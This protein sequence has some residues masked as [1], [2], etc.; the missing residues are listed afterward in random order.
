MAETLGAWARPSCWTGSPNFGKRVAGRIYALSW[1]MRLA[2]SPSHTLST[3]RD[4]W[5]A[6][7]DALFSLHITFACLQ[8]TGTGNDPTAQAKARGY[9]QAW[10]KAKNLPSAAVRL[11][12]GSGQKDSLTGGLAAGVAIL[13]FGAWAARGL[14]ARCWADGSTLSVQFALSGPQSV[15]V[16]SQYAPQLGSTDPHGSDLHESFR[17]ASSITKTELDKQVNTTQLWMGDYNFSTKPMYRSSGSYSQTC[18]DWASSMGWIDAWASCHPDAPGF[19]RLQGDAKSRI[20]YIWATPGSLPPP[21]PGEDPSALPP[22]I[23]TA[24]WVAKATDFSI[25]NLPSD[26]LPLIAELDEA[27]WIGSAIQ[28]SARDVLATPDS[29]FPPAR[30]FIRNEAERQAV[31]KLMAQTGRR[32]DKLEYEE[33]ADAVL[34]P[35]NADVVQQLATS[36]SQC[37]AAS[38]DDP[39]R[40]RQLILEAYAALDNVGAAASATL[41]PRRH[42]SGAESCRRKGEPCFGAEFASLVKLRRWTRRVS[43]HGQ[44]ALPRAAPSASSRPSSLVHALPRMPGD[45]GIPPKDVL[46]MWQY[47]RRLAAIDAS[48]IEQAQSSPARPRPSRTR[49]WSGPLEDSRG[50]PPKP[51]SPQDFFRTEMN[52]LLRFRFAE[53]RKAGL[54]RQKGKWRQRLE[55]YEAALATGGTGPVFRQILGPQKESIPADALWVPDGVDEEGNE[56]FK[57]LTGGEEVLAGVS[58]MGYNTTRESGNRAADGLTEEDFANGRFPAR[59]HSEPHLLDLLKS[60]FTRDTIPDAVVMPEWT[61]ERLRLILS[62]VKRNTAA[63][64]SGLSYLLLFHAPAVFQQAV[65]DL[66]QACQDLGDIPERARHSYIFPIAKSGPRGNTLDGARQICLVEVFLKLASLN[67]SIPVSAL[68][69]KERTLHVSQTG[70]HPG[71]DAAATAAAVVT[72]AANSRRNGTP[73]F[74]F[75]ADVAKAFQAVPI[76]GMY[77]AARFGGMSHRAACYWLQTERCSRTGKKATCQFVTDFGLSP[78]FENETGARMGAPPSPIKFNSWLDLL[79]RW[80]DKEGIKGISVARRREDGSLETLELHTLAFADDLLLL[81]ESIED[82]QR[83]VLLVDRFLSLF[84]VSL[85]PDKSAVVKVGSGRSAEWSDTENISLPRTSPEGIATKVAIHRAAP[86]EGTRYLGVW[87]QGDGRWGSMKA[88]VRKKVSSW[89]SDL[90]AAGRGVSASR[91]SLF[92][93]ATIGGYLRYVFSAAPLPESLATAIDK[94]IGRAVAGRTGAGVGENTFICPLDAAL[95]VGED[96]LGAFSAVALRRS[97]ILSKTLVRLI[98]AEQPDASPM[99]CVWSASLAKRAPRSHD[100]GTWLWDTQDAT[101][102]CPDHLCA[103]RE[104]LRDCD[105]Q[106]KDDRH[107]P[108][109]PHRRTW[110]I[111]VRTALLSPDASASRTQVAAGMASYGRRSSTRPLLYLGELMQDDGIS[112]HTARTFWPSGPVPRWFGALE[113]AILKDPSASNRQVM[114]RWRV[115][116]LHR[117]GDGAQPPPSSCAARLAPLRPDRRPSAVVLGT[118]LPPDAPPC[119]DRDAGYLPG[120]EPA[121]AGLPLDY[122]SCSDGTGGQCVSAFA[123]A[124]THH[125]EDPEAVG[126]GTLGYALGPPRSD[127]AELAG[128]LTQLRLAPRTG[129][130]RLVSDCLAMLLLLRWASSAPLPKILVHEHRGLLLEWRDLLRFQAAPPLLGWMRG[131]AARMDAPYLIQD[132][133]DRSAPF[134]VPA[135]PDTDHRAAEAEPVFTLWDRRS[136]MPVREGWSTIVQTR[137]TELLRAAIAKSAQPGPRSWHGLRSHF[138]LPDEWSKVPLSQRSTEQARCRSA[139]QADTT[140]GPGTR[141]RWDDEQ[142]L[143]R[144]GDLAELDRLCTACG[145]RFT[146]AWMPHIAWHC[147][148]TAVAWSRPDA[149]FAAEWAKRVPWDPADALALWSAGRAWWRHLENGGSWAGF[150][151]TSPALPGPTHISP[152]AFAATDGEP[153]VVPLEDV[154]RLSREHRKAFREAT[155]AATEGRD[156]RSASPM[157]GHIALLR[158]SD[159]S[160]VIPMKLL[161]LWQSWAVRHDIPPHPSGPIAEP[162]PAFTADVL[163]LLSSEHSRGEEISEVTRHVSKR[164]FY[165]EWGAFLAWARRHGGGSIT[166]LFTGSLNRTGPSDC[167]RLFSVNPDDGPWG[168]EQDA[169]RD[170]TSGKR[171][172]WGQGRPSGEIITGNPPFDGSSIRQFCRQAQRAQ[173]PVLGILPAKCAADGSNLDCVEEAS[174][175][176]GQVIAHFGPKVRAFVPFGFWF[177][178]ES[179]GLDRQLQADSILVLW[180]ADDISLTAKTELRELIALSLPRGRWPVQSQCSSFWGSLLGPPPLVTSDPLRPLRAASTLVLDEGVALSWAEQDEVDD[181]ANPDA[182]QPRPHLRAGPRSSAASLMDG[183]WA[184]LRWWRQRGPGAQPIDVLDP[185]AWERRT[186]WGATPAEVHSFL[187]MAGVPDTA[188]RAFV[189]AV[190]HAVREAAAFSVMLGRRCHRRFLAQRPRPDPSGQAQDTVPTPAPP[191]LPGQI[192]DRGTWS[193]APRVGDA[194]IREEQSAAHHATVTLQAAQARAAARAA[195]LLQD[196]QQRAQVPASI[197]DRH[198]RFR[199]P[200]SR[201][202]LDPSRTLTFSRQEGQAGAQQTWPVSLDAWRASADAL[203]VPSIRNSWERLA[204]WHSWSNADTIRDVH[205]FQAL[206]ADD[207]DAGA[208]SLVCAFRHNGVRCSSLGWRRGSAASV[209][210]RTHR[211]AE[212]AADDD[213]CG[214]APASPHAAGLA[215]RLF[216]CQL[217]G[218]SGDDTEST[219]EWY[220]V[221]RWEVVCSACVDRITVCPVDP[222]VCGS[223]G[224]KGTV[225]PTADGSRGCRPCAGIMPHHTVWLARAILQLPRALGWVKHLAGASASSM[226]TISET[227]RLTI[228]V[229][230]ASTWLS[231]AQAGL[232]LQFGSS[233]AEVAFPGNPTPWS[234]WVDPILSALDLPL[235]ANTPWPCCVGGEAREAA[236]TPQLT[237]AL[238]PAAPAAP[239]QRPLSSRASKG[240]RQTRG[241]GAGKHPRAS[242]ATTVVSLFRAMPRTPPVQPPP[243]APPPLRTDANWIAGR[244]RS[245]PRH[246]PRA[247]PPRLSAARRQLHWSDDDERDLRTPLDQPRSLAT[248]D[249]LGRPRPEPD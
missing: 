94:S 81:A 153:Q 234:A 75:V 76:W 229:D 198:Q 44:A 177:G 121:P 117:A 86:S 206:R 180:H 146:G 96:G 58:A 102:S 141:D 174:R 71:S 186:G 200:C 212:R 122:E 154:A 211:L 124:I 238:A 67:M 15:T 235:Q 23:V 3:C 202:A 204:Q 199:E 138:P 87:L 57:L 39:E 46:D 193:L 16:V 230:V 231:A 66:L 248:D 97:V 104:I 63:G 164:D 239:R 6:L 54:L 208:P 30:W 35:E 207:A 7:L 189:G 91:A 88:K 27:K 145:E 36:A 242:P 95:P 139:A 8:E 49:H 185:A 22:D 130:I 108:H 163:R 118:A 72:T 115:S 128:L 105:L 103:L 188:R 125:L 168:V 245:S 40:K 181:H 143:R 243:R 111:L 24:S 152:S 226:A 69:H 135:T 60:A 51:R 29:M 21:A 10:A 134:A 172:V 42:Q 205:R 227:A 80:L 223:C 11:W 246:P 48:L 31:V 244:R 219:A 178:R 107:H 33:W 52:R 37:R 149:V 100:V 123:I 99:D 90:A 120:E 74:L 59:F 140:W 12:C 232:R 4:R 28:M 65:A 53:V 176:G 114:D 213:R 147:P 2:L 85:Q 162:P 148:V 169:F 221:G 214:T 166:E 20:D 216:H 82:M 165:C 14:P 89:L 137:S 17:E 183:P 1:N 13:A 132:F 78:P 47:A 158:H 197:S 241:S 157:P 84:G 179:C 195:R 182:S 175:R 224:K 233:R 77:I 190:S 167:S 203:H 119:L 25:A 151:L 18:A 237:P 142:P 92:T 34:D 155:S 228:C 144:V 101:G 210:C 79:F 19:T 131:H 201:S 240:S 41:R 187:S 215:C 218:C 43:R 106:I 129:R 32:P 70:F 160:T 9:V 209:R 196:Q 127:R 109:P 38:C 194:K 68:W 83:L 247:A 136:G 161:E 73:L 170:P 62:R 98:K 110:D 112:L 192:V 64:P 222:A 45:D 159:G 50:A 61:L 93:A 171:R 55:A 220:A 126:R 116:S 249:S 133:C 156:V 236:L 173:N 56:T 150:S 113:A 26:H 5:W 217:C 191:S 184:D 225:R